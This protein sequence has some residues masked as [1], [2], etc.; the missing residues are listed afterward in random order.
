MRSRHVERS[1]G[2]RT[3]KATHNATANVAAVSL[4]PAAAPINA[5]ATSKARVE[6]V[7]PPLRASARTMIQ[8]AAIT[9]ATGGHSFMVV[10]SAAMPMAPVTPTAHAHAMAILRSRV[11]TSAKR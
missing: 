8:S 6:I 1:S 9:S 11:S 10:P 5:P 2:K 3:S 7:V 4:P